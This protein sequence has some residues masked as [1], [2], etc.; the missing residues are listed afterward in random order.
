[1][2]VM[3][4]QAVL[5]LETGLVWELSPLATTHTWVDARPECLRR[6]VGGKMGW[7]LPSIHELM[8]LLVPGNPAGSP[9]LPTGHP[10]ANVQPTFYWSA[11]T[12]AHFPVFAWTP[13][14]SDG[15]LISND[16]TVSFPIWCVRGG[17]ISST[18]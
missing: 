18:Y 4:N 5:D 11:T 7:R 9:D 3:G 16:K 14:F 12:A 6:E 13:N 2:L 15:A 10:F 17:G 1:M 8:S